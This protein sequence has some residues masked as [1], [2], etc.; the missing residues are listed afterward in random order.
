MMKHTR[1]QM[2]GI[3]IIIIIINT[4]N[5]INCAIVIMLPSWSDIVGV[6][7]VVPFEGSIVAIAVGR[8][9][10]S[11]MEFVAIIE[12]LI[13]VCVRYGV[14]DEILPSVV[15]QSDIGVAI[16]VPFE[17]SVVAFMINVGS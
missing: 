10:P 7:I 9:A 16:V 3:I 5:A 13:W 17:G 14:V 1:I 2:T 6:A 8:F 11:V 15:L 4:T 12:F